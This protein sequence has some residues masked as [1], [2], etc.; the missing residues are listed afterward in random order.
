MSTESPRASGPTRVV[1]SLQAGFLLALANIV[2]VVV[3]SFAWVHVRTP[4]K[5]LSVTGS[6][7]RTIE[8]DLIV[9]TA[10]VSATDPELAKA[11]E[12]LKASSDKTA[13]WLK[14]QGVKDEEMKLSSIT[15]TKHFAETEKGQKTD[16]ITGY[17]L[18]QDLEV[19]SP[20][21]KDVEGVSRNITGL[22]KDGVELES[23]QP[24]FL[25][26]K[27]ADLKIAMLADAT[28]DATVRA[29]QIA[30]NSNGRLGSLEEARMGVMQINPVHSSETTGEGNNDTTSR[31]KDVIAVVSAK[32]EI[33]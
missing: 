27:L 18:T 21:V 1:V 28:K 33:R 29:Q 26:T 24:Q 8:S 25:Y 31:E 4:P 12:E 3:F 10:R 30:Q 22:I 15:T 11:Y 19:T 23:L 2:C 14:A 9:W 7:K 20:R 17:E 16:R 5:S 32:F 6:A 13:A